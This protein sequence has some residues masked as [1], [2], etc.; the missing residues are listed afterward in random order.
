LFSDSPRIL[1]VGPTKVVSAKMYNK[2]VLT[3]EAE[4]NPP[5]RYSWLQKLPTQEV[6]IRGYSQQ[7]IIEN[8]TYDYQGEFVC[9]ATN[10][11]KSE[12]RTVQSEPLRVEV[13]GA[14]QVLRYSAK[15]EV[16]VP[17]GAE[18]TLKVEFCAN[19]MSNQSWHLGDMGNGSGNKVILASGTG[20]GRF[21]AETV[22]SS[23]NKPD[24]YISTLR[25]N[26]AHQSDSHTYELRLSNQ[27]GIDSHTITLAVKGK[28]LL[29]S[30]AVDVLRT[31]FFPNTP[32]Y[33]LG[34]WGF[35]QC[36]GADGQLLLLGT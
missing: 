7:L 5:P 8:V 31:I 33:R 28:S 4:G 34:S 10:D 17:I 19:P 32:P 13:T 27:H 22:K 14:P 12:D 21:V 9:K 35:G 1:S 15:H 11:I 18:A 6:L 24:C 20:H 3:C 16:I 25:I 2:T 23:P 29:N 26:G 30:S 36:S